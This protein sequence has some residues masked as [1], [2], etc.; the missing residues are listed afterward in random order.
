VFYKEKRFIW[1]SV[2]EIQEHG[3]SI[4]LDLVRAFWLHHTVGDSILVGM[5][6]WMQ[7]VQITW[8]DRK[9][10]RD[11]EEVFIYFCFLR[12]THSCWN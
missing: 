8:Q 11:S 6:A 10:E 2:L 12:I 4:C 1:L 3:T 7:V 9:P 5:W